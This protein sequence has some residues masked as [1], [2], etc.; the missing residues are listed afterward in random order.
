MNLIKIN[1]LADALRSTKTNKQGNQEERKLLEGIN[2][3]IKYL[4]ANRNLVPEIFNKIFP[5]PTQYSSFFEDISEIQYKIGY[6]EESKLLN[7]LLSIYYFNSL[8]SDEQKSFLNVILIGEDFNFWSVI[9]CLPVLLSEIELDSNFIIEWYLQ[10]AK[11][12]GGDFA[13]GDFFKAVENNA[14]QFP[15]RNIEALHLL[16]EGSLTDV[17]VYLGGIMLGGVRSSIKLDNNGKGELRSFEDNLKHNPNIWLKK[18]YY[19]SFITS[20][21]QGITK[22]EQVI[23]TL[24]ELKIEIGEEFSERLYVINRCCYSGRQQKEY[25]DY[26]IN[27]LETL[28]KVSLSKADK[29]YIINSLEL[30]L[31]GNSIESYVIPFKSSNRIISNLLP[32]P[33]EEIGTWKTLKFYSMSLLEKSEEDFFELIRILSERDSQGFIHHLKEDEFDYLF[34][35]ITKNKLSVFITESLISKSR[36]IRRV[37]GELY[38]SIKNVPLDD[39][40]IKKSSDKQIELLILEYSY[41]PFFGELTAKYFLE[42]EKIIIDRP[43]ELIDL[44][45]REMVFQAINYRGECFEYWKKQDNKSEILQNVIRKTEDYFLKVEKCRELPANSFIFPQFFDAANKARREFSRK[46]KQ[47]AD[48]KSVFLQLVKTTHILYSENCATY[49]EGNLGKP[50][51]MGHY[52]HSMEFPRIEEVDPEGLALKKMRIFKR[53]KELEQLL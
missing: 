42:L 1:L 15:A 44:F 9:H 24:N 47:S 48:K 34:R 30:M 19:H 2:E 43:K 37:G 11:K 52:S 5:E 46:V 38:D 50:S 41:R 29:F 22:L 7:G 40:I 31:N 25:L 20:F 3:E 8:N 35:K 36:N 27:H 10:L 32:I 51:G 26:A 4:F 17:V 21:S 13:G 12:I 33:Q 45:E 14:L 23:S 39:E 16:I 53:I 49:M 18:I 28:T 6:S